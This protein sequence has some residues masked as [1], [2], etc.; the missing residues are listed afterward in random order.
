MGDGC[1]WGEGHVKVVFWYF[2][3]DGSVVGGSVVGEGGVFVGWDGGLGFWRENGDFLAVDVH[4]SGVFLAVCYNLKESGIEGMALFFLI[5]KALKH[6]E[7][8]F[9]FEILV[10][11]NKNGDEFM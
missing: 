10:Y 3:L 6:F 7:F 9:K 8:I 1:W 5:I 2:F 4:V 11:I